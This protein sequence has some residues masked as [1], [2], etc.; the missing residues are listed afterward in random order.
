MRHTF[1]GSCLVLFTAATAHSATLTVC[2]GPCDFSSLQAA[3]NAAEPFD[4]IRLDYVGP[5]TEASV[6]I[7]KS[8]TIEG[9]PTAVTIFQPADSPF[10]GVGSGLL[11]SAPE[12][13]S[14][15]VTLRHFTLR[16][17]DSDAS[18]GGITATVGATVRM[19]DMIIRDNNGRF[20]GAISS[21]AD[22][23]IND[24]VLIDNT[25]IQSGGAIANLGTPQTS[26]MAITDSLILNNSATSAGGGVAIGENVSA[27]IINSELGGNGAGQGGALWARGTVALVRS[28]IIENG[29]MDGAGV[30]LRSEGAVSMTNSTI[31]GNQAQDNG[32]GIFLLE[33]ATSD[34]TNTH[35]SDNTAGN[36]GGGIFHNGAMLTLA[37]STIRANI[38]DAGLKGVGEG[39]G[40]YLMDTASSRLVSTILAENQDSGGQY[41]DCFGEFSTGSFSLIADTGDTPTCTV[42]QA[43]TAGMRYDVPAGLAPVE[44]NGHLIVS[45][46]TLLS[47]AID[48]GSCVD[49]ENQPLSFDQR[50]APMPVDGGTGVVDCDMGS[51]EFGSAPP[52][53]RDGFE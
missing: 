10:S 45:P 12:S 37:N 43:I 42:A 31:T 38:A 11:I 25:A 33:Q 30:F 50:D 22:L 3:V 53:F 48:A 19:D 49:A 51:Y 32:G 6:V 5:L 47:F 15:E 41:P 36:S 16:H 20:G 14:I 46:L 52:V 17:G 9:D 21:A 8:L 24:T 34:L 44:G 23:I 1:L 40:V 2:S 28:S 29:A 35:V 39:G 7:T 13:T 4:T 27:T 26:S 18:G